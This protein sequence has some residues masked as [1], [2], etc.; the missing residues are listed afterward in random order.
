MDEAVL[1]AY[2]VLVEELS[3]EIP[4]DATGKIHPAIIK[5]WQGAIET[6]IKNDMVVTGKI[7]G[8]AA[9]IDKDQNVLQTDKISITLQVQP[10]GYADFIEV[11]IG[12]TTNIEENE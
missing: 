11:N 12:F 5:S 6:R 3:D 4:V 7:S 10:V 8:V 9:Y 2:D 1:T